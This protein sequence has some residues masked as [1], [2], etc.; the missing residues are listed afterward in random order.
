MNQ[1]RRIRPESAR[2]IVP[3]IAAAVVIVCAAIVTHPAW[4]DDPNAVVATV[5]DHKISE[6]DLDAKV[7]PQLDQMRAALEK[8]VDQLIADK[9]F[10]LRRQTLESM[11]DDYLVEQA[12]QRDKLSADDYLKKE[13]AGKSAVTEADAKKFYDKN[14]GPGTA[15]FD[16]IKPGAVVTRISNVG[17]G[18]VSAGHPPATFPT[19]STPPSL[20]V[21]EITYLPKGT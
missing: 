7:K 16:K 21:A 3:A 1:S 5:G 2:N 20:S 9:T 11:T 6:K 17:M 12:A 13:Y 8:R 10:D 14:K 18:M 4:A 15:P 19:N